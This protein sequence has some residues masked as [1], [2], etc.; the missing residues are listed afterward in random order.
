MLKTKELTAP[1]VRLGGSGKQLLLGGYCEALVV[2]R[3]ADEALKA[4]RPHGRDYPTTEILHAALAEHGVRITAL[5]RIIGEICD[6][7]ERL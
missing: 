7:A 6:L 2:L 1:S 3:K 5:D 4:I